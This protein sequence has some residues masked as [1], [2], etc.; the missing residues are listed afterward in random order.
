MKT[1]L[2]KASFVIGVLFCFMNILC[3]DVDDLD[4][5]GICDSQVVVDEGL[6]QNLTSANFEFINAE[7][8]DDCLNI[9]IGAS[10]CDGSSWAFEL[11][12]SEAIAE[13]SPEQRFLKFQLVNEEMCL[14]V[15]ES[16]VS[17]D[18][19]PLQIDGS[20]EILLNIE[21]LASSLNYKY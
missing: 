20:S 6:Y 21:G 11:V 3:E 9:E 1:L 7:I 13:S 16:S 10:G 4:D 8:V 17:F 14:A 15:F 2:K 18:L 5:G 12:A 19:T